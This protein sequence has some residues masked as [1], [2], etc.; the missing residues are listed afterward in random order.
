MKRKIIAFLVILMAF[1][2]M[3]GCNETPQY[4]N[5]V[6]PSPKSIECT[7]E[8]IDSV[9]LLC[10][11]ILL[12]SGDYSIYGVASFQTDNKIYMFGHQVSQPI[13]KSD[14]KVIKYNRKSD[15]SNLI[16]EVISN[17][18]K[19]V[20]AEQRQ[21]IREYSSI[22]IAKTAQLGEAFILGRDENE[23]ICE[24]KINIK[25]FKDDQSIFFYSSSEIEFCGGMSG[26][27]I[28]QN[29]ELIG[30]HYGCTE[31]GKIGAGRIIW[32]LEIVIP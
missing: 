24:Y 31:D 32:D 13:I 14:V 6:Q 10:E 7:T 16:G 15:Y 25:K 17:T 22:P 3:T 26:S 23:N 18:E 27:P 11:Y 1:F 29:G 19:G 12:V 9:E 4:D 20:I 28:I 21:T 30:V 2:S 5:L 8:T